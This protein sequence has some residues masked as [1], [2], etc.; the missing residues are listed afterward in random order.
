MMLI[1]LKRVD[2]ISSLDY[3]L[4]VAAI[5]LSHH[6][7]WRFILVWSLN[8]FG[9]HGSFFQ[10]LRKCGGSLELVDVSGELPQLVR[11]PGIKKWKVSS[12]VLV[13]HFF[14]YLTT[15]VPL[16]H[17][18]DII[19]IAAHNH[20]QTMCTVSAHASW[21]KNVGFLSHH[22]SLMLFM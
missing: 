13:L 15:G 22:L 17:T 16:S 6:S 3:A 4:T 7:T 1:F 11:R 14:F 19:P 2:T 20:L 21:A 18:S 8:L 9:Q 10:I 12:W 5:C